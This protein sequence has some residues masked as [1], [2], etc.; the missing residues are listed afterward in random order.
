MNKRSP[1]TPNAEFSKFKELTKNLIAVPKKEIDEKKEAYGRNKDK[2][3]K[4]AN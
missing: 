3:E 1:E 2:K 4:P